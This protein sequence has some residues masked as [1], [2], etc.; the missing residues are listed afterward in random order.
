MTDTPNLGLPYLLAAQSQ[1]HVTHNDAIRALDALVQM[2]VINRNLAIPPVSP[3]EGDRHIV[4]TSPSGSWS[5]HAGHVAAFQDGAW[6]FYAPKQGWLAWVGDENVEVVF[7]GT[8]WTALSAGGGGGGGV[9][10]HGALTGLADDDH[11]QYHNDARGDARYAPIAPA[12][13][14]INATADTTNRLAVG[15]AAS[16]FNHAGS[17]GHQIKINK[18]AAAD[19]ASFLFQTAFSGRAELG[20]AGDDDFH[21]KVSSN[22]AAWNDAIV[23]DR[24]TGACTFPNTSLGSG[25]VTSVATGAGL[26]GGPIAG[27]GTIS[28]AE[29][30]ANTLKGNNTGTAAAPADLTG[31]QVQALLP[32]YPTL[33]VFNASGTWTRPTGCKRVRVRVVGGGGGGAG[34]TAAAS[35]LA[36]GGGGASGCYSEGIFDVTAVASAAVTVGAAGAAGAAAN[37]TGGTGG[38]SAFGTLIT[39]VGGGGGG[40]GMASGTAVAFSV[41][42]IAGAAGAGG[43]VVNAE[44]HDGGDGQRA[45]GT[46]GVTGGS[47]ASVFGGAARRTT[48]AGAGGAGG[49]PGAGGAGALSNSATGYAGGAGKA[50]IVIIEEYY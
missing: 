48:A 41:G 45:S 8:V 36:A 18:A 9:T 22:G 16:L 39:A 6:M 50:G 1:K 37:G 31:A 33:Q 15:S 43:N 49:A 42:G 12:M 44:G 3:A 4:A 40:V 10:V 28:M 29:M 21:F 34:A 46:L 38:A 35:A 7:D 19:T 14:G 30:A 2:A 24:T 11:P 13:L 47:G 5:G 32:A 26:T 27:A 20:T 17:G 25:T 23:I